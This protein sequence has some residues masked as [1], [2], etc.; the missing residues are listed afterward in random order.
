MFKANSNYVDKLSEIVSEQ[1]AQRLNEGKGVY[2]V[3]EFKGIREDQNF[4]LFK[5][6]IQLYFYPYEVADQGEG[7]PRFNI[8]YNDIDDI[9][10]VNNFPTGIK[11]DGFMFNLGV[12][13]GFFID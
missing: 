12:Y 2:F 10:E 9:I 3:D 4:I 1:I 5:D 7:F 11:G 8:P 6:Y 13:V